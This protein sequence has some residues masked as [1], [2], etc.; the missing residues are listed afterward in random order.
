MRGGPFKCL[1]SLSDGEPWLRTG[2]KNPT[3][4]WYG[5]LARASLLPR[6]R[7]GPKPPR[8]PSYVREREGLYLF[9]RERGP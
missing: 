6:A 2:I 8:A 7:P 9:S 4:P 5:K 1:R 3:I